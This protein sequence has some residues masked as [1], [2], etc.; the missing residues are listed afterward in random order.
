M[1]TNYRDLVA[2]QKAMV[3]VKQGYLVSA[4]FPKEETYGLTSQIRRAAVS[5]PSNIAEGQGRRL[6]R[7]FCM[8]L[9]HARGS[10]LEVETQIQIARD[11]QYVSTAKAEKILALAAELGRIINGLIA[12]LQPQPPEVEADN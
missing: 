12:S 10:L 3:F 2:W 1:G 9:R 4:D 5:I 7:G 11:L 6:P 8:F